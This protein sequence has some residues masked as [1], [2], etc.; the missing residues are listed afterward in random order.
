MGH[1]RE[2]PSVFSGTQESDS[3]D[4]VDDGPFPPSSNPRP[5]VEL[6]TTVPPMV[7]VSEPIEGQESDGESSHDSPRVVSRYPQRERRA[8]DRW[9]F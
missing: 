3:N 5:N 7:E 9:G 4:V 1:I 8:P 2:G 6:D